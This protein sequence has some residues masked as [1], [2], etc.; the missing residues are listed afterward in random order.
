[1]G[2]CMLVASVRED[3]FVSAETPDAIPY[4]SKELLVR[5]RTPEGHCCR[6]EVTHL[7][8][9]HTQMVKR[10]NCVQKIITDILCAKHYSYKN[11]NPFHIIVAIPKTVYSDLLLS[12][13][14]SW[15]QVLIRRCSRRAQSL[16][17]RSLLIQSLICTSPAQTP[18]RASSRLRHSEEALSETQ[19]SSL[20]I[21]LISILRSLL[22]PVEVSLGSL[23]RLN[24]KYE[25]EDCAEGECPFP[26]D[27]NVLEDIGVQT[28][29]V[30]CREHGKRTGDNS[31][32][33][34]PVVVDILEEWQ[35]RFGRRVEAKH[36][37]SDVLELPSGNED[38]PSEFCKDGSASTEDGLA[39]TFVCVGVVRAIA[40][41]S[42]AAVINTIDDDDECH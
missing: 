34:E 5:T 16:P 25:D 8:K 12:A 35:P 41:V 32:E 23:P 13:S 40:V 37:S 38:E 19:P 4:V 11:Q 21:T 36:A 18:N 39:G 15:L 17:I 3:F 24:S 7:E 22:K 14:S 9:S 29:N 1:M 20:S 31:P 33:K 42:Q 30:D 10:E 6:R 28:R 2:S 26:S 27:A